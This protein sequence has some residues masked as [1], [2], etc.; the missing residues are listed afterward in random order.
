VDGCVVSASGATPYL[1]L[2][3]CHSIHATPYLMI[4]VHPFVVAQ[5]HVVLVHARQEKYYGSAPAPQ[6]VMLNHECA[7]LV[8]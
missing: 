1:P 6:V 3:T 4:P 5:D 7:C 2:H 8:G